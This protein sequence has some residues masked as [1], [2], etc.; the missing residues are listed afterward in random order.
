MSCP[1]LV[2]FCAR[3]SA[4]KTAELQ[5]R[6]K[7]HAA[8]KDPEFNEQVLAAF[9]YPLDPAGM[10]PQWTMESES[11]TFTLTQG[12]G[13][14][15]HGFCRRFLPAPAPGG[16]KQR[17]PQALCLIYN[18]HWSEFFAK[19]LQGLELLLKQSELLYATPA[20]PELP[21]HSPAY[22]FLEALARELGN[23]PWH[24]KRISLPLP[25]EAQASQPEGPNRIS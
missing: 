8:D 7:R 13:G 18:H 21:A 14:R 11:Y 19:A 6:Y 25:E 24:G 16:P 22:A 15:L 20:T 9:C 23:N 5:L 4:E 3:L 2:F 1:F 10:Q 17:Y 12:D